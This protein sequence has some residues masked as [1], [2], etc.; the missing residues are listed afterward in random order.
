M[1]TI[2]VPTDLTPA[3]NDAARYAI[4]FAKNI[5]A[6]LCLCNALLVPMEAPMA[7]TIVWPIEDYESLKTSIDEELRTFATKLQQEEHAVSVPGT[8]HPAVI[9]ATEIG[10][11]TDVIRNVVSQHKANLVVMG[12]SGAGDVSRFF[13][14]SKS[15]DVIDI[16][17]FPVLLIPAQYIFSGIKKIAFAT[18]LSNGDIEIIHSLAGIARCFNAD[19][20]ISHITKK[21]NEAESQRMVDKFL[22]EVSAKVNYPKI[23]YRPIKNMNVD[24]G[25]DLLSEQSTV[26]II[27]MVHRPH[28]LLTKIFTTSHTQKLA[29]HVPKPLLVFPDG[30]CAVV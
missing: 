4:H 29:K 24:D 17:C 19:I 22:S 30:Y 13:L 26:D 28:D 12:M 10:L 7:G 25:L 6:N 8:Y 1:K 16:A 15:R 14:G 5:K 20:L 27:A 3:A 21:H 18:D 23:Y 11:V 9:F 2:V